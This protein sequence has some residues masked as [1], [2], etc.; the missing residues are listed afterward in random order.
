MVSALMDEERDGIPMKGEEF[1]RDC[2]RIFISPSLKL[3]IRTIKYYDKLT[4]E[5]EAHSFDGDFAFL[6]KKL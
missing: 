1:D 4:P 5:L 6:A 2:G 3:Q